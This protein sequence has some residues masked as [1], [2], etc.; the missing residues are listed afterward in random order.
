MLFYFSTV[1]LYHF[2]IDSD[3]HLISCQE[4]CQRKHFYGKRDKITDLRKS[5][6]D[7]SDFNFFTLILKYWALLNICQNCIFIQC[8]FLFYLTKRFI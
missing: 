1:H 5:E 4:T 2:D 8:N 3:G 7:Q 6:T